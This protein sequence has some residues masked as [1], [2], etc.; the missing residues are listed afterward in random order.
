MSKLKNIWQKYWF[1]ILLICSSI[2][3]P[4]LSAFVKN[5]EK[6]GTIQTKELS[7]AFLSNSDLLIKIQAL[8]SSITEVD[9]ENDLTRVDTEPAMS[10]TTDNIG[11]TTESSVPIYIWVENSKI[12]YYTIATNINLNNN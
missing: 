5:V 3:I 8:D 7:T 1:I 10:F 6:T 2:S 12:Y 4:T 9:K 11:S